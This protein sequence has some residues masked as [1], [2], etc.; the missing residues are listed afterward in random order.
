MVMQLPKVVLAV[1]VMAGVTFFT[2]AFPFIFFGKNKPP[3]AL[4]FVK[5]SIPPAVMTVLVLYCFKDIAWLE[6]PHGLP[7]LISA[8]TVALLHLWR[9]NALLS[10]GSGTILYMVLSRTGILLS[11]FSG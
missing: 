1:L 8:A 6:S 5:N 2:R 3:E 11:L 7:E 4:D 9:R 10:I